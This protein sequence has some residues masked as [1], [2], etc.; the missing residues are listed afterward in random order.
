MDWSVSITLKMSS[1]VT[2]IYVIPVSGSGG[3]KVCKIPVK[4][5]RFRGGSW[6]LVV[7]V[8]V[9]RQSFVFAPTRDFG[10]IVSWQISLFVLM[11]HSKGGKAVEKDLKTL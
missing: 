7:T 8:L 9:G 4:S 2:C 1:G 5:I 10:K 3:T 6:L 11:G